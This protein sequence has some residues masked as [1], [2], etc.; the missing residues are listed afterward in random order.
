MRRPGLS[1][2]SFILE[3]RASVYPLDRRPGG[4]SP[5]GRCGVCPWGIE[6]GLPCV[7]RGVIMAVVRLTVRGCIILGRKVRT[8]TACLLV[9]LFVS[10]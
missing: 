2:C 10:L 6:P 9:Q 1:P 7:T 5:S 3:E 4:H 8:H